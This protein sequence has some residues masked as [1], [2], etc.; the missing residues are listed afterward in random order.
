MQEP[1]SKCFV[2]SIKPQRGEGRVFGEI[3]EIEVAEETEA[4]GDHVA[5][6]RGWEGDWPK[7][8]KYLVWNEFCERFSFYGLKTILALFMLDFLHL[9]ETS[10]T[11][12]VH[13]FIV[14]SYA[15]P[16][17]GAVLSDGVLGKYR[18]ILYLSIV[19]AVGNWVLTAAALPDTSSAAG[20]KIAFWATAGGLCLIALGTGGIKPCVSA[21]GGDQI[22]GTVPEGPVRDRLQR[23]FFSLYYAAVNAGAVISTILT[24]LLRE[25]YAYSIAFSVP[26]L[27]MMVALFIFWRGQKFYVDRAPEGNI[28]GEVGLIVYDAVKLQV[29]SKRP[30]P[31]RQVLLNHDRTDADRK[32]EDKSKSFLDIAKP[33]HGNTR[34]E[35][36]KGL[37]QVVIV[38]LPAPLFWSL[39]DQQSSKWIFQGADMKLDI[40]WLGG[41]VVQPDQMQ[42]LNP[43]LVLVLIPLFDQLIYPFVENRGIPL[44]P[45]PRMWMGIVLSAVA[46]V[47]SG[48]LQ[49][50]IDTSPP[51]SVSILW[52][53]P[54]NVIV[55]AGEILL[56]I[57]GLEF[58]YSQAPASMKS[59][60]QSLWLFTV[61]GGNIFTIIIV[62]GVGTSLSKANEFFFFAVLAMVAVFAMI[63]LS[64]G[65]SYKHEAYVT[66]PEDPHHVSSEEIASS[67]T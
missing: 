13:L 21:F 50:W 8:I 20:E 29:T 40:P 35:D 43:I 10:S 26:A 17:L 28:F 16:L 27:L 66:D 64:S 61:A 30:N 47:V 3:E 58:A 12:L 4:M 7:S 14:M 33:K 2:N 59:I 44:K 38:L 42:A 49:I 65:F 52:Q 11:E 63:W 67:M 60:V 24:P 46:F 45:I 36:I 62:A 51:D 57:T 39:S 48:L 23:S 9:S 15:T 31:E 41:L 56:S 6:S 22:E 55:T 32:R 1:D 53:I 18:T 37:I 19:Y 34:V 54:Q 25:Y 5:P